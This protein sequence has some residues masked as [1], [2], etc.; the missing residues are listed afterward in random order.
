MIEHLLKIKIYRLY[1]HF[2]SQVIVV[3]IISTVVKMLLEVENT[4][5]VQ[6][7]TNYTSYTSTETTAW[8]CHKL[9][10]SP[11]VTYDNVCVSVHACVCVSGFVHVVG[12]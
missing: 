2:H 12:T 10:Q 9:L 6:V 5:R 7:T 3:E 8:D 1:V 4:S 11:K